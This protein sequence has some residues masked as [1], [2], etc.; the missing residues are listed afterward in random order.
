[1]LNCGKKNQHFDERKFV[2]F[3]EIQ[4]VGAISLI[5][6][7]QLSSMSY[8]SFTLVWEPQQ[9]STVAEWNKT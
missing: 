5:S 2:C 8:T 7:I 4:T 9:E 6:G 3:Q 1:M